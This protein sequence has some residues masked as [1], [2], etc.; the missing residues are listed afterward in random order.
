MA[1]LDLQTL[2]ETESSNK[3]WNYI[4]LNL[5]NLLFQMKYFLLKASRNQHNSFIFVIE[6]ERFFW[7][8][9]SMIFNFIEEYFLL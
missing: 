2:K 5:K 9:K 1:N 3:F 7:G 8:K 6:S 4:L